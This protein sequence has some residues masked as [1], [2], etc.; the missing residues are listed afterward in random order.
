MWEGCREWRLRAKERKWPFIDKS[1]IAPQPKIIMLGIYKTGIRHSIRVRF[2][3]WSLGRRRPWLQ[4][5][6][7]SVEQPI[8]RE[9]GPTR[10]SD[11]K[12]DP[13]EAHNIARYFVVRGTKKRG[14]AAVLDQSVAD[15][16][17]FHTI[18]DDNRFKQIPGNDIPFKPDFRFSGN[19]YTMVIIVND[20][21]DQD[22]L[23]I[24]ELH[25]CRF[26]ASDDAVLDTDILDLLTKQQAFHPK[27]PK[28]N[29]FPI[30]D[31]DSVPPMFVDREPGDFN[32]GCAV[33]PLPDV[34]DPDVIPVTQQGHLVNPGA[35]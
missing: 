9:C 16:D 12:P 22:R 21:S 27:I 8:E 17:G 31:P 24:R 14:A 13:I 7:L 5:V 32:V 18:A 33:G 6:P 2:E 3:F 20:I 4:V 10:W 35:D 26:T 25:P 1:R 28:H 15:E 29:S 11:H 30:E 23:R 19:I 34:Q